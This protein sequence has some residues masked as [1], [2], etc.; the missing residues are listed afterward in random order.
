MSDTL[1]TIYSSVSVVTIW[2]FGLLGAF[3]MVASVVGWWSERR[4]G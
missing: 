1:W 4:R 3:F 2:A